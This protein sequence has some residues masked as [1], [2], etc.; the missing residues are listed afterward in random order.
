[1]RSANRNDQPRWPS[2]EHRETYSTA[3]RLNVS[4][5]GR[6]NTSLNPHHPAPRASSAPAAAP[7]NGTNGEA[8]QE[9]WNT[10]FANAHPTITAAIDARNPARAPTPRSSARCTCA[11][12]L[13]LAPSARITANSRAR[14]SR[15]AVMAANNTTNPAASVKVNKNST[16]RITWSSTPWIWLIEAYT[17][18][19]VMLGKSRLSALSKPGADAA[20]GARNAAM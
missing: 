11:S 9:N 5:T 2:A 12:N 13:P 15:V 10:Y 20:D 1:M 3:A 19:L 16:A 8:F 18:T 14:A 17:S 7:I 4:T 6:L